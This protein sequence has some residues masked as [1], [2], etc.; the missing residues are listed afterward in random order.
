MALTP[1]IFTKMVNT[2]PFSGWG[3][4]VIPTPGVSLSNYL[5]DFSDLQWGRILLKTSN[6]GNQGIYY[7]DTD[8]DNLWLNSSDF[9]S[10]AVRFSVSILQNKNATIIFTMG[11]DPESFLTNNKKVTLIGDTLTAY[12]RYFVSAIYVL[13]NAL[14]IN[15]T[16]IEL[17]GKVTHR[18][19]SPEN[20]LLLITTFK[21][22][23][24]SRGLTQIKVIGPSVKLM[25][26]GTIDNDFI[27]IFLGT[28]N[29]LDCWS[30]HAIES[31]DDVGIYQNSLFTGRQ[32]LFNRSAVTLNLMQRILPQIPVFISMFTS[33]SSKFSY[34]VDYGPSASEVSEYSLRLSD[35]I[36]GLLNSGV[37]NINFSYA[38]KGYDPRALNRNDGSK[39]KFSEALEKISKNLPN[40]AEQYTNG[41]VYPVGDETIK[42]VLV[43]GNAYGIILS[44]AQLSD[45]Y[46]GQAIINIINDDWS[47]TSYGATV[48]L[49]IFPNSSSV[50]SIIKNATIVGNT[51]TVSL[52]N[53][54]Y[55]CI[56]IAFGSVYPIVTL[57]PQQMY[58]A[59][60]FVKVSV[61]PSNPGNGDTV[62]FIPDNLLYTFVNSSWVS[63]HASP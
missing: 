50:S 49:D 9:V 61:F 27:E 37:S 52:A 26:S 21:Q 53:L 32:Y 42:G 59:S 28:T 29:L 62:F 13:T 45:S 35:N 46:N 40:V 22:I 30:F 24:A 43:G 10:G 25:K 58:Q 54:P 23:L 60:Q 55:Q 18:Y 3:V 36:C 15:V 39:R 56:I 2:S 41:G 34:G 5:S 19:I 63:I 38:Y 20:Y 57:P 6:P 1:T 33:I 51:L 11:N 47:N 44:R 7:S 14:G 16:Y 17:I 31:D 12:A 48:S 8:F 4:N